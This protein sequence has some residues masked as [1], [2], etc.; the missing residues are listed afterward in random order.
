M[1]PRYTPAVSFISWRAM[2][3]ISSGDKDKFTTAHIKGP[4]ET[5]EGLGLA[6]VLD[7]HVW[8]PIVGNNLEWEVLH[9]HL[10]PG[11]VELAAE[12]ALRVEDGVEGFIAP[13]FFAASLLRRSVSEN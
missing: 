7:L 9:V 13:W 12:E 2:S 10:D 5:H 1:V 11:F 8:L 6:T 3:E 4:K